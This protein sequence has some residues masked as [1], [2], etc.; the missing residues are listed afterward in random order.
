MP[1]LMKVPVRPSATLRGWRV[2]LTKVS[3]P[4][5]SLEFALHANS[6]HESHAWNVFYLY[7][8]KIL[9]TYMCVLSCACT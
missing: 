7:N 4:I 9:K 5:A 3:L 2:P 6:K 8:N 1:C